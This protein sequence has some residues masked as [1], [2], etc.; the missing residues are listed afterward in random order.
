MMVA[1]HREMSASS[2]ADFPGETPCMSPF[3]RAMGDDESDPVE[4]SNKVAPASVLDKVFARLTRNEPLPSVTS[5]DKRR[6]KKT[7]RARRRTAS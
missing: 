1:N 3:K 2:F 6:N 7:A 4:R 5:R